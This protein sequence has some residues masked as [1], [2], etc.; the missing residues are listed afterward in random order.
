MTYLEF[1]KIA[2]RQPVIDIRNIA[3]YFSGLNAR[4]LYEWQQKGYI[5]K[6]TNG[7]YVLTE[8]PIDEG[9]LRNI[10][11]L[12]CQPSYIGLESALAYYGFIPEAVFQ[13]VSVTTRR[14]RLIKTPAGDFRYRSIHKELF[15]AIMPSKLKTSGFLYPIRKRHCWIWCILR[16]ARTGVRCWRD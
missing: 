3:A 1:Q 6:I 10:A 5:R 15:L 13:T 2:S 14:S 12:I 8:T 16:P 9:L 11:S 7:F 4:R